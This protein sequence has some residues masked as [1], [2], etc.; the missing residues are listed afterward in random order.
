M[1]VGVRDDRLSLCVCAGRRG[2]SLRVASVVVIARMHA[3]LSCG[4]S[5]SCSGRFFPRQTRN[6]NTACL[7]S[8]V[9]FR[10]T[11]KLVDVFGARLAQLVGR[12]RRLA[13]DQ[14]WLAWLRRVSRC[15]R[16]ATM[17]GSPGV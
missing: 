11:T 17:T 4:P 2:R 7:R 15:L 12:L 9:S 8:P 5:S 6:S 16:F 1:A 3:D 14:F 10:G 13:L